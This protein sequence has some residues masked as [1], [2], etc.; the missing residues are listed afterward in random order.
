[1]SSL[2]P[3]NCTVWTALNATGNCLLSLSFCST[4]GAGS[5]FCLWS[6]VQHN[7]TFKYLA[8]EGLLYSCQAHWQSLTVRIA[9]LSV[10][11]QHLHWIGYSCS[12]WYD[13]QYP[14]WIQLAVLFENWTPWWGWPGSR[15]RYLGLH[16]PVY[17]CH[18]S[19]SA[20][21]ASQQAVPTSWPP[22]SCM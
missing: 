8:I 6:R 18:Q 19:S 10:L 4:F 17:S 20:I 3:G 2:Q 15:T 5:L 13:S 14:G 16:N 21:L 7:H 22:L 9:S 1:M 11:S 12:P